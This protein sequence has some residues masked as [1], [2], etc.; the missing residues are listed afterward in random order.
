[1]NKFDTLIGNFRHSLNQNFQSKQYCIQK[2]GP[3]VSNQDYLNNLTNML[4]VKIVCLQHSDPFS[5][6]ANVYP[7][8]E[9]NVWQ[10]DGVLLELPAYDAPCK[11]LELESLF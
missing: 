6:P 10:P 2:Q 7:L 9:Q 1:M 11:N 4:I 5:T 8:A 3:L